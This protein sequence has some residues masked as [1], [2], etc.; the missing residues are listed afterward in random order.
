MQK[1]AYS[2]GGHHDDFFRHIESELIEF[3]LKY[4]IGLSVILSIVDNHRRLADYEARLDAGSEYPKRYTG[5]MRICFLGPGGEHFMCGQAIFPD[6]DIQDGFSGFK[7]SSSSV[8]CMGDWSTFSEC[9]PLFHSRDWE[10]IYRIN[11]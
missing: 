5:E 10:E 8:K 1:T 11:S 7:I 9:E 3:S 2:L 4:Q 6:P